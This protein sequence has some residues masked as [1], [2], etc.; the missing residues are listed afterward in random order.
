MIIYGLYTLF[1]SGMRLY[2]FIIHILF[3]CKNQEIIMA[4][5]SNNFGLNKGFVPY[6]SVNLGNHP[7]DQDLF[8][9]KEKLSNKSEIADKVINELQKIEEMEVKGKFID[10][11]NDENI[12]SFRLRKIHDYYILA[13]ISSIA[14]YK[15]EAMLFLNESRKGYDSA[16]QQKSDD[17]NRINLYKNRINKLSVH[18]T[19]TKIIK[20]P[21]IELPNELAEYKRRETASPEKLGTYKGQVYDKDAHKN[22]SFF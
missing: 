11:E 10:Y 13:V 19:D 2:E 6:Y 17:W 20:T 16:F 9:A 14:G 1:E 5:T 15:D 18:L 22:I 7:S 21:H 4:N 8:N 12:K 3:I